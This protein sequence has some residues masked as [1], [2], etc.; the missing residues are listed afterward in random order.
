MILGTFRQLI[1]AHW[2]RYGKFTY[3]SWNGNLSLPTQFVQ[4]RFLYHCRAFR[5]K[6]TTCLSVVLMRIGH[7]SLSPVKLSVGR[8]RQIPVS[9]TI[10]IQSVKFW[11]GEYIIVQ[12]EFCWRI[13]DCLNTDL[14][15]LTQDGNFLLGCYY[16]WQTTSQCHFWMVTQFLQVR[17]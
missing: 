10:Y 11:H 14:R 17:F 12:I 7:F 4:V 13:L 3:R 16:S 1:L 6:K 8:K 2:T 15:L 5:K 9:W